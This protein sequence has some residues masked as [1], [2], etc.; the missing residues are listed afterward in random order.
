M[1]KN[2]ILTALCLGVFQFAHSQ[3]AV[4][5]NHETEENEQHDQEFKKTR[6]YKSMQKP[7]ADYFRIRKQFERYVKQHPQAEGPRE[8]AEAW[9]RKNIY[10]LDRKGRVQAPPA[11]DYQHLRAGIAPTSTV[12]DTMAGDWRM[13]GPRNQ[14][15]SGGGGAGSTRGGYSYCVRMDP[16]NLQ[17]M[18][19]SFL[20]GGLWVSSNGGIAW[21]LT[22][23]NMPNNPYFDIV[24]C[25]ANTNIVYAVSESAVIKSTDGGYTW[26]KTGLNNSVAAYSSGKGVDVA[27]SPADANIVVA[28]WGTSIY[29][30]TDGGT[31]WTS[32][33]SGLNNINGD[34]Y[35]N[36]AGGNMEWS[37]NDPNRVFF[38]D[39][40]VDD[41]KATIYASTDKGATFTVLANITI[42]SDI[43]KQNLKYITIA[44]ATDEPSAVFS[45]LDSD[46]S[47]MQLYKTDVNT[48][49]TTLVRKNMVNNSGCEAIAMDIKNS[50]NIIYGTY[51]GNRVNYSTNNGQSFATSNEMHPDIRNIHIVNGKVMV[52]N[53]GE[54]VVSNDKGATFYNVSASISNIELW[55]FGASF[56]SDILAAGCNH[57]PLTIRDHAGTGG[58]YTVWG[59]DQQS[60]DI[61]PLD[62]VHVITRGY[63]VSVVTRTGIGTFTDAPSQID[64]GR[65]WINNL[66][67]H[68]NL[69]N[70][71]LSH[72]EGEN[73]ATIPAATRD[74][75]KK[76]LIRSDD[77]GLTVSKVVYTFADRLMS[78]KICMSDTNRIYGIVGRTDNHLWK[79]T[80]GGVTWTEITPNTSVTGAVRNISDVAV[81][82][83]NSNEIWV[84]YS[85]VQNTCKVLHSTDGGINYTNLTT[86]TLKSDPI[87][88]IIFQRGTRGGVYVGNKAGVFYR[89]NNM[90]D[91]QTLGTG[92]PMLDVSNLFINYYK[93]KLLIG[94][95]R[96]AWDH[97]L[98][99]PSSTKAQISASTRNPSC[100][101][102]TV[103]FRD[104]SVV[105]N[106]G[107]GATYSWQFA[108][109]TPSTST[110]ETPVVDYSGAAAG[111]YNVTLTVTGQGGTST[112][113][114][115]NFIT[116]DP[117][118]C[119]QNSA[120]GWT[121]EDIG[122]PLAGSTCYESVKKRFTV[123]ASGVDV[124]DYSDQFRFNDTALVGNGQIIARVASFNA[125][126]PWAKAGVMIRENTNANS[127]NVFVTV[128]PG[129]GVTFQYR[130]PA[131]NYSSYTRGA[132]TASAPYW[133]KLV[134][135]GNQ[136]TG[137]SSSNGIN[138]DSVS[139]VNI[140]MNTTVRIGLAVT[141]H[142]NSQL[143]TAVFDSVGISSSCIAITKQPVSAAVCIGSNATFS[144]TATGT[145]NTYQ[146]Q[147]LNGANE[148]DGNWENGAVTG[149]TTATL[150]KTV[151]VNTQNGRQWRLRITNAACDAIYSNPV[152]VTLADA[153]IIS[154]PVS[155][156]VPVS[157]SVVFRAVT[158]G[159]TTHQW[160]TFQGGTWV[161]ET[162]GAKADG[163]VIGSI[164]PILVKQVNS[165]TPCGQLWRLK[166]SGKGICGSLISDS[167][168]LLPV[169]S[170]AAITSNPVSA[171][172]CMGSDVTFSAVVSGTATSY[173][174]QIYRPDANVWVNETDGPRTDGAVSGATTATLRK[175]ANAFT[176]N[177]Q[178][179]RLVVGNGSC[180][181]II[182]DSA[183]IT[184]AGAAIVTQPVSA[185]VPIGG[186]A[187]FTA[188]VSGTGNTYQ[189]QTLWGGGNW[190]NEG[191]GNWG[192][193][194]VSGSTTATLTKS[195]NG[196]TQNG[197]QWRLN[198]TNGSCPMVTSN[199]VTLTV[200]SAARLA[201]TTQASLLNAKE[202]ISVYP[203]PV[204]NVLTITGMT[205]RK[206]VA[207][208]N[209]VGVCI[210]QATIAETTKTIGTD[211][212]TNGVY[213][214]KITGTD[215]QIHTFEVIKN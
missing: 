68:P 60:T 106:A 13:I 138:W 180:N 172:V 157:G 30:S 24:V 201:G 67:Y 168:K 170:N 28:R 88:K 49:A 210:Y 8:T 116:Y 12:T 141:N 117:T 2:F 73:P 132:A 69:F 192:D 111:S 22:D 5:T 14:T 151:N 202:K 57:G 34:G 203:N 36:N 215:G 184:L 126:N 92:L 102:P 47:Y 4:Q 15:L 31:T 61:N 97:D 114:L 66:S 37:N 145:N 78:E 194:A 125:T 94:T 147:D 32:V 59:A 10:Y 41:N 93:G 96:G 11:F 107:P 16:T 43:P 33:K 64:P 19:I 46:Y 27:V 213:I 83:S 25:P 44:T 199:A 6:W 185:T 108:G 9:F 104:Y 149:S 38:I 179:R 1:I 124:W 121:S 119:C 166:I 20:T 171:T 195:V 127:Q 155:T 160:Q 154:Q 164:T 79:T 208:Y 3:R 136:F 120:P 209:T 29:R 177:Y 18:F 7:H 72:T 211:N 187:T 82:D 175:S 198:V 134:R 99:E 65:D 200:G 84:A 122:S 26:D 161:D 142:D 70:T 190:Y 62:S 167:V 152:A 193:G 186:T 76:S 90:N 85:G 212:W 35:T 103:Q 181:R 56:K 23:G 74:T 45:F 112:Q 55:G 40:L 191:D 159:N 123:K 129:N 183:M 137:Y 101:S 143:A 146:W 165:A 150:I 86:P 133:I 39:G 98:Y 206:I 214:V 42:P 182:S 144:A 153:S 207:V 139:T 115:S 174:W 53:D 118:G 176:E 80:D 163:D 156:A 188:Q 75:W 169:V 52:G 95:N 148:G 81:S 48:G 110:S 71:I 128:T 109:G 77:N 204:Q 50:N 63:G 158:A 189:W 51:G 178:W 130:T 58:W 21:H 54:T 140:E 87:T 205:G 197:R 162:D 100:Q 131:G 105:S 113:T 173:Q 89:N 196:Y 17:K 135:S 91:W